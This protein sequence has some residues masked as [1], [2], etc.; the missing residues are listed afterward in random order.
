MRIWFPATSL[1]FKFYFLPSSNQMF[2]N[3][4]PSLIA[5]PALRGLQTL[6]ALCDCELS[7][8]YNYVASCFGVPKRYT[9]MLENYIGVLDN[10]IVLLAT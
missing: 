9:I 5:D 1:W 6:V 3:T 8:A 10:Y 4:Y 7:V 2:I